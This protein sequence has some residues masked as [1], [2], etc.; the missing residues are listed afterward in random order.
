MERLQVLMLLRNRQILSI[1]GM[2][3]RR[4]Q[5]ILDVAEEFKRS[6]DAGQVEKLPDMGSASIA[7]ETEDVNVTS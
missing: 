6:L 4:Q 7:A 3:A 2:F 1:G 5:A